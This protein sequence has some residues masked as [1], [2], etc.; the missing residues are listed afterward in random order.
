MKQVKPIINHPQVEFYNQM[1][2]QLSFALVHIE[3]YGENAL[4]AIDKPKGV[5]YCKESLQTQIA[6]FTEKKQAFL[7]SLQ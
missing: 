6:H 5:A 3:K 1:I 4:H 2:A 7:K